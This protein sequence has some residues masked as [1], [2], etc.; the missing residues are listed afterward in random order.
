MTREQMIDEAVRRECGLGAKWWRE[1]AYDTSP[2]FNAKLWRAMEISKVRWQFKR[3]AETAIPEPPQVE[4]A[5][6]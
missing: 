2:H 4:D 1:F 3:I 6:T 5:T